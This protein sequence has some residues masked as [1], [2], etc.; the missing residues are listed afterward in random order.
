MPGYVIERDIPEIRSAERDAPARTASVHPRGPCGSPGTLRNGPSS[1]PLGGRA[2]PSA[3]STCTSNQSLRTSFRNPFSRT[4][5][6]AAVEE[7]R[8]TG[9]SAIRHAG[10][11]PPGRASATIAIAL[12]GAA[13]GE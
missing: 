9:A 11:R 4:D 10:P 1:R 7:F 8:A 2:P 12:A 6:G 3:R 5:C 13:Y